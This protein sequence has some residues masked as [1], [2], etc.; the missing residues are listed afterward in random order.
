MKARRRKAR[1]VHNLS[2]RLSE[3]ELAAVI[4]WTDQDPQDRGMGHQVRRLIN[5]EVERERH[6]AANR[7]G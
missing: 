1:T 3:Q 7:A 2:V 4:R 6:A 5:E